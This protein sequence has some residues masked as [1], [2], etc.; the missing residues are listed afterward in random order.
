MFS[1]LFSAKG[2]RLRALEKCEGNRVDHAACHVGVAVRSTLDTSNKS[3][4]HEIPG[5]SC[6]ACRVFN[7]V[8][9]G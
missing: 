1:L 8:N 7:R 6:H 3:S 5:E 2:G 4:F 9:H